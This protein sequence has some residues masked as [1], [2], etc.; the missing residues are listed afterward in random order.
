V[1]IREATI[2][3]VEGIAIVHVESWRTAYKGII[4]DHV[5]SNLSVEKRKNNWLWTFNN[6][7]K[8]EKVFVAENTDGKIVGFSSGGQIRNDEFELDGELY[9]IYLLKEYQGLRIGKLLLYDVVNSLKYSGYSSMMVWVLKDNPS[10][11]FY[12]ALGGKIIGQKEIIIGGGW[13]P[14]K[15]QCLLI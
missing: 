1:N 3:D 11:G 5:L 12:Q 7:N 14:S 9:A 10:V 8:D 6:L 4:S 15:K 2:E 13:D